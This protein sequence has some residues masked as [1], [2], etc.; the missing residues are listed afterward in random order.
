VISQYVDD[1]TVPEVR[2][3]KPG[4]AL[5]FKNKEIISSL[6]PVIIKNITIEVEAIDFS[7][8]EKVEFHIDGE[9]LGD[10]NTAPYTW[11][12]SIDS[13]KLFQTHKHTIKVV[14]FDNEGNQNETELIVNGYKNPILAM[15]VV[16]GSALLVKKLLSPSDNSDPVEDDQPVEEPDGLVV[17]DS[18]NSVLPDNEEEIVTVGSEEDSGDLMPILLIVGI[19]VL[20]LFVGI[21]FFVIKKR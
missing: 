11:D 5:Y 7:G 8:I 19:A 16:G 1:I 2:I 9:Y 6:K 10:D 12:W 14:A 13:A 18:N 21:Y 4:N 15:V 3:L 20:V 17:D